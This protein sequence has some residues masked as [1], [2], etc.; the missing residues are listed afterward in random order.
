MIQDTLD[1]EQIHRVLALYQHELDT[2]QV[3]INEVERL[4]RQAQND[5][6]KLGHREVGLSSQ[7]RSL[8]TNIDR[9]SRED[10]RS[11]FLTVHEVQMRLLTARTQVEQL[12]SRLT[13]LR[14]R[15]SELG[16]LVDILARCDSILEEPSAPNEANHAQIGEV[17][18]A[19]EKERLRISLQMHDGPVQTLSNLVLRADICERLIDRDPQ[20]ARTE[21]ASLKTAVH[22]T[23]QETRRFVFEL[24][25]MLLDDLG[26]VP[27]LRRYAQDFSARFRVEVSIA[28]QNLDGRLPAHYEV[29]L[30]RFTQEA[31]NNVQ[32]HAV[33]G[34]A[35][36]LLDVVED[37]VQMV[38]EDDGAGF[39]IEGAMPDTNGHRNMGFAV[40]RQQIETL[41]QGQ[42]GVE[43]AIGRGTRVVATVPLRR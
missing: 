29:A 25:P 18:Q 22:A 9:F 20:Q 35:R 33:A 7:L 28:V 21:L 24:R 40:M 4:L 27:T 10:I 30:F 32:K 15:Q 38:I 12:Q 2:N 5:A 17:I 14:E 42:L 23:L 16:T 36:I 3:E 41:L 13:R 31:L 39:N 6:D 11:L 8:Q 43:S 26:L 34:H 1:S 19:Q 37:Q